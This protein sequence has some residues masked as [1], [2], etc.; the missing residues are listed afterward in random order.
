MGVLK[1]SFS[2]GGIHA[3]NAEI[4][5]QNE[6]K[7][8][9][10]PL[11]AL[12]CFAMFTAWQISVVALSGKALS[13]EGRT[14]LGLDLGNLTP[15]F[16][17]GYILSIGYMLIFPTKIVWAERVMACI[18]LL[19]ALASVPPLPPEVL[20]LLYLAQLFCCCVMIGF[21][22]ALIVGL[23]SDETAVKHLLAA[24]ALIFMLAAFMQ[25]SFYE[26]PY[27]VFE[28][29]SVAALALQLVF[30]FRLPAN[31]WPGYTRKG[32]ALVCPKGL[33]AGLF[34]LTF[35]GN[36]LISFG[37]SAAEAVEHGMFVFNMSFAVFAIAGYALS[38]RFR[39]PPLRYASVTVV[40]SVAGFVLFI[41]SRYIHGLALPACVLLG[42]GTTPNI[43]IPYYGVV[44]SK[45]YPSRFISPVIVGIS[46]VAST[47]ILA[48]LLELFR[49]NTT[50]LYV[51]YL[52]IAVAM[53][54][55]Y[56][57]VEPY[58]LYSFRG[59]ALISN[60]EITELARKKAGDESPD[61]EHAADSLT[62]RP[63][64]TERLTLTKRQR[65]LS[66]GA[67]DKLSTRELAIAEMLMQGFKYQDICKKFGITKNT[68]YWYRRQLFDKLQISSIREMF[69][70]A[71]KRKRDDEEA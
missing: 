44:M 53:A 2:V 55:L 10:L 59:K 4:L 34:A 16:A 20:G 68:V 57:L 64:L 7:R 70:L 18:A 36:I 19:A 21:E 28:I 71:E 15:V 25:N 24:Y 48:A 31:V 5:V 60:E 6:R 13:V 12:V 3:V 9:N 66:A 30:Y 33:F 45:P 39:F 63:M 56:L 69:V 38:R 61:T 67:F 27:W 46:F 49:E 32:T 41:M 40:A 11:P 51:V 50:V 52:A 58:L 26:T 35:L 14:P 54:A 29:F 43:L 23:F 22:T 1:Y 8:L 65:N 42:A 47:V 62:E 17:L 37:M